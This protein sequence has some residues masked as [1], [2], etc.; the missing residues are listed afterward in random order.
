MIQSIAYTLVLGKPV[1]MY[2]GILTYLS[3]VSTAIV[4]LLNFKGYN[5]IPF[6]WHPRLAA[7]SL[8]LATVHALLGLSVYFHF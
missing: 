8:I 4:G 6:R 3:F 7:T 5:V 1:V 2:L